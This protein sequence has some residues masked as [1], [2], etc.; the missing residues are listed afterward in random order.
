MVF[1][2]PAPFLMRFSQPSDGQ[3]AGESANSRLPKRSAWRAVI[4]EPLFASA[5]TT[6]VQAASPAMM[7]LRRGKTARLVSV[8]GSLSVS[9]S[10]FCRI[11]RRMNSF[12][13]R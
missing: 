9:S 12:S 10:P 1:S 13:G 3:T 4:S 8:K 11:R 5:R 6:T 7:R 2:A